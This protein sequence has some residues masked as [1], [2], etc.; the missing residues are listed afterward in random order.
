MGAGVE[1]ALSENWTTKVEYLYVDLGTFNGNC[2]TGACTAISGGP[3]VP[4][5][6]NLTESIVRAGINYKFGS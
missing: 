1:A 2:A 3:V 5:S 4:F 6:V